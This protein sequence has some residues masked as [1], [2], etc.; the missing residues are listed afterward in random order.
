MTCV[1]GKHLWIPSFE[2]S[3]AL[4]NGIPNVIAA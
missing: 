3:V 1:N 4:S 2:H